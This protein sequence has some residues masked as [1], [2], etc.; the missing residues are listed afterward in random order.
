MEL[1]EDFNWIDNM[2][3]LQEGKNAA[4]KFLLRGVFARA[5]KPNLNKRIYP[6]VVMEETLQGLSN[7]IKK[8][9]FVGELDHPASPKVSVKGISHVITN[10]QLAPD[11]AVLGEAEALDTDPG[12]QLKKLME[13]HIRLGVSTRG[14]GEIRP[15]RGQEFGEGL[16][17]V[18]PGYKM[19][20]IDI[21]FNPSA[22]A[23]PNYVV[24]DIDPK[25]GIL[26]GSTS[27]FRKVWED[28]FG[29]G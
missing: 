10:L 27:S 1:L 20:A 17:E 6:K 18:Q 28:V 16:V 4:K 22:G 15:Y 5:G 11:G 8:R 2:T 14:T 7:I 19:R 25:T 21:V 9:G 13:A 29:N 12:V 26:L 24:E 23:Y 3:I